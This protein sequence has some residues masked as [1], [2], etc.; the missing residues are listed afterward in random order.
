MF[1]HHSA[2]KKLQETGIVVEEV[3]LPHASDISSVYLHTV[4][5]E[6][7]AYHARTLETCPEAYTPAIRERLEMGRYILGEDYIRAMKGRETL[8]AAV[9]IALRERHG[10][11]L[12]TLPIP[13]PPLGIETMQVE[14][15]TDSVRSLTLRLSQLFNLTGHPAISLP[16]DSTPSGLPCGLQLV[17]G[18]NQTNALLELSLRCEKIFSSAAMPA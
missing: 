6:A 13:A 11:I 18:Y 17:G 1:E 16:I 8:R 4:L 2:V 12:P 10:L 15:V 5:P 7:A 14:G 3:S 9:D